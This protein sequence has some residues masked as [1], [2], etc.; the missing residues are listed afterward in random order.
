MF[1]IY[2]WHTLILGVLQ[3]LFVCGYDGTLFFSYMGSNVH[4]MINR[5]NPYPILPIFISNPF[6]KSEAFHNSS[7]Y[8]GVRID[9]EILK[10]I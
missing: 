1:S 2:I 5:I 10:I 8:W 4:V 7:S 6:L 9:L 3:N